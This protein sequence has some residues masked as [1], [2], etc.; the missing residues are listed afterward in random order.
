[1]RL[2]FEFAHQVIFAPLFQ[3]PEAHRVVAEHVSD[4]AAFFLA[5]GFGK[6]VGQAKKVIQSTQHLLFHR[7]SDPESTL[8]FFLKPA[9]SLAASSIANA[10]GYANHL[11]MQDNQNLDFSE[12][13]GAS[14]LAA[15]VQNGFLVLA[16]AGSTRAYLFREGKE[17]LLLNQPRTFFFLQDPWEAGF[18]ELP[19]FPLMALGL[20]SELEPDLTECRVTTGDLFLAVTGSVPESLAREVGGFLISPAFSPGDLSEIQHLLKKQGA[21]ESLGFL[22]GKFK[23]KKATS[24][25][26]SREG[27]SA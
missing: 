3:K 20:F 7:T 18:S 8:P 16:N 19:A 5:E 12:R 14:L 23:E 25:E 21:P 13:S 27:R 2:E 22:W 10:V 24:E 11:L 17:G 15:F 4:R 26:T 6:Q 9:F 1:M